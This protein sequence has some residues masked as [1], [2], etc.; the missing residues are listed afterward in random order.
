MRFSNMR[1]EDSNQ[2]I[3]AFRMRRRGA[4]GSPKACK[5]Y[6]HT[7]GTNGI[8][9]LWFAVVRDVRRLFAI[10]LL[11]TWIIYEHVLQIYPGYVPS[12]SLAS[13]FAVQ[14]SALKIQLRCKRI[15]QSAIPAQSL[16]PE[17]KGKC[18]Q[19][20]GWMQHCL[21]RYI[22]TTFAQMML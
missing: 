1:G 18:R 11:V 17:P 7:A 14:V 15:L 5:K 9:F 2:Q 19:P 3:S 8:G 6:L 12:I 20:H 4:G 22:W 13:S 10:H 16:M 21:L